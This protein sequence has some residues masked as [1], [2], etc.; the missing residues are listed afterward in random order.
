ML[1]LL[2]LIAAAILLYLLFWPVPVKPISW[3]AP[4]PPAAEGVYAV[5]GRLQEAQHLPAGGAGP[6]DVIFDSQGRLYVGLEDGRIMSMQPDG[7][8]LEQFSKTGG[9]PLGLAFDADSNLL[10]ADADKGLLSIDPNGKLMVL[11]NQINGRKLKFTNHEY[12]KKSW[13]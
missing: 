13:G 1:T 10:I 11:V 12:S 7:S 3:K 2:L 6:E 4:A 9:R 8:G 5:N